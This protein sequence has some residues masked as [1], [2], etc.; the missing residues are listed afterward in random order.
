VFNQWLPPYSP[1]FNLL[2]EAFS[3]KLMMK[4]M[5]IEM[6]HKHS[7]QCISHASP[8][9]TATSELRIVPYTTSNHD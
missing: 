1:D 7:V 4:A 6:L 2:E 9:L 3:E 5:E 8:K